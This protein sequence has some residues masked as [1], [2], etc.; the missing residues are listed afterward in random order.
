MTLNVSIVVGRGTLAYYI[1][2]ISRLE[3]GRDLSVRHFCHRRS[4]VFF[5]FLP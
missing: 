5:R 1:G 4:L 3:H 2:G